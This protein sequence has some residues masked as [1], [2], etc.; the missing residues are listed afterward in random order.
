MSLWLNLR[1]SL[2]TPCP[3]KINE[4]S[5]LKDSNQI[6]SSSSSEKGQIYAFPYGS[7]ECVVYEEKGNGNNKNGVGTK[8][9][10]KRERERIVNLA[11]TYNVHGS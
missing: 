10:G 9:K 2:K 7:K 8:P 5:A 1:R 11:I 6:C 4:I 3:T